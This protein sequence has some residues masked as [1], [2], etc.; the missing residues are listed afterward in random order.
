MNFF[1]SNGGKVELYVGLGG[2][3]KILN[4]RVEVVQPREGG[5]NAVVGVAKKTSDFLGKKRTL[6]NRRENSQEVHELC[7]LD[8]ERAELLVLN[9]DDLVLGVLGVG[10]GPSHREKKFNNFAGKTL[11]NSSLYLST[12]IVFSFPSQS[13]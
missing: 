8:P 2:R 3:C 10:Q 5:G 1:Q 4:L 6:P 13:V 9:A 7:V 11:A 12:L